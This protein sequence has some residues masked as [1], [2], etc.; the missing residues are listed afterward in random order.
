[1]KVSYMSM[2]FIDDDYVFDPEIYLEPENERE[3]EMLELIH[4]ECET[5]GFGRT[6]HEAELLY[7]RISLQKAREA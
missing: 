3:R 6:Y 7:I 4:A 2:A 5:K 1:M